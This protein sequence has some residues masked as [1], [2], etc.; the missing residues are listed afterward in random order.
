[1]ATFPGRDAARS[2]CEALLRRTGIV[3]DAGARYGPGSAAHRFARA[4]RC[5]ASGAP[6]ALQ[7]PRIRKRK[8]TH[9]PRILVQDQGAGDRRFGALAAVFAFAEPAVD[10]NRR[11]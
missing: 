1:M 6:R 8:R 7:L 10:A 5:T 11:A 4:T 2:S 3:R 9:P